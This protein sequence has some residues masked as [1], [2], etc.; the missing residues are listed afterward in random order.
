MLRDFKFYTIHSFYIFKSL[1]LTNIVDIVVSLI[2][3]KCVQLN[4]LHSFRD[5][6][7]KDISLLFQTN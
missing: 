7:E 3:Q 1:M 6:K 2:R 4:I 5:K